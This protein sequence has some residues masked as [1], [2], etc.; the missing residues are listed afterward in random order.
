M[1]TYSFR[2][3]LSKCSELL[4]LKTNCAC[5]DWKTTYTYIN[6]D[7]VFIAYVGN[8]IKVWVNVLWKLDRETNCIYIPEKSAFEPSA[9]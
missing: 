5:S 6:D 2:A 7:H 3:Q 9:T 1:E 4:V 8:N